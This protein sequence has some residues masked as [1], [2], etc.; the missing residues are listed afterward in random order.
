MSGSG[1]GGGYEYQA[2]ATAYVAA[3]ILAEESLRWIEDN[4]PDV[5]ISVAS[6][7][8]GAGD[9][10]CITLR[11][12]IKIE[13]QAKHGLQKDKLWEPL[14]KLGKGLKAD[15]ELY[16]V[17][18]TDSTASKTIRED[19]RH[20]FKRLGQGRND[21]L[22]TITKEV[23]S[24]FLEANLPESDLEFF[25][26]MVII[27]RDL[28][29]GLQDGNKVQYLLSQLLHDRNQSASVWKILCAEGLQLITI[30][31]CRNLQHWKRL[32]SSDGIQL[33]SDYVKLNID[34]LCKE[35]S[36]RSYKYL[37]TNENPLM[38]E[39]GLT[40]DQSNVVSLE[41]VERKQISKKRDDILSSEQGS[42][43]YQPTENEEGERFPTTDKFLDEIIRDRKTK[44]SQGLRIA[45][46]G[47]AGAGKTTLLQRIGIYLESL[48]KDL[49]P[50]WISLKQVTQ[51]I[52][53]YLEDEYLKEV[54]RKSSSLKIAD[55]YLQ[56]LNDLLNSGRVVL[57]LDGADESNEQNILGN[58]REQLKKTLFD[59]VQVILTC[60]INTWDTQWQGAFDVYRIIPFTYPD[61]VEDFIDRFSWG[62]GENLAGS[63][64]EVLR[65]ESKSRLRDM[66]A[67]P[68]RL[69]LLCY[70][71]K[72]G[73]ENLPD[74]RAELY[75]LMLKAFYKQKGI[76]SS[77][78]LE[79]ALGKL[80]VFAL[81]S[82]DYR[83]LLP[84]DEI[85][86]ILGDLEDENSLFWQATKKFGLL[87][88]VGK[89]SKNLNK[90]TYAFWH[91]TFQEYFAAL[92]ISD[93]D[94]FLPKNH[95]DRPI[96]D[97]KYRAFSLSWEEVI[98]IWL[99]RNEINIKSDFIKSLLHFYDGCMNLYN[100]YAYCLAAKITSEFYDHEFT[101]TIIDQII[102]WSFNSDNILEVNIRIAREIL[103]KLDP[104]RI[105]YKLNQL[106][107]F[108]ENKLVHDNAIAWKCFHICE[109]LFKVSPHDLKTKEIYNNI[110]NS[111]I[112]EIIRI[113]II[114]SITSREI[115]NI[116]AIVGL[117][118]ILENTKNENIFLIA[119]QLLKELY[120]IEEDNLCLIT[121]NNN[122]IKTH[123]YVIDYY[124]PHPQNPAKTLHKSLEIPYT[125]QPLLEII[126][127]IDVDIERSVYKILLAISECQEKSDFQILDL[128]LRWLG[129]FDQR[130][131]AHL[132]RVLDNA[133]D[134]NT[135]LYMAA[136]ILDVD[137]TNY[138]STKILI[139]L[140]I[141]SLDNKVHEQCHQYLERIT[142]NELLVQLV[143][144]LRNCIKNT[145]KKENFSSYKN[146]YL[147]LWHCSQNM[148][149]SDFYFAWH[150]PQNNSSSKSNLGCLNCT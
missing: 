29:E 2:R 49:V 57:L 25:R 80:A 54:T 71:W 97:E 83:Y 37:T 120:P 82:E 72:N 79:N 21:D 135:K 12:G 93:W 85:S 69:A 32:L 28:D 17:I 86:K 132:M 63:L 81:D 68:L 146:S 4:D 35:A 136:T 149:Y 137:Q 134:D 126:D 109:Y 108:H 118:S 129:I 19:L 58:L 128:V 75:R 116:D 143:S 41:I 84:E 60:R 103:G 119:Q 140:L 59:N 43:F 139:S 9:D 122:Y 39:I 145:V 16:G 113:A 91:T 131:I 30:R 88:Q 105:K 45:I 3:H 24:K 104:I 38:A 127:L 90:N 50:I 14:I 6:E 150:S 62:D 92:S 48:N 10:L 27:V 78:Q 73:E 98:L 40:A 114:V 77:K 76:Q 94:F 11:S 130:V 107:N 138:Y 99:G 121:K 34:E 141:N 124:L 20:D 42:S 66:V 112:D 96:Q 142:N 5:P 26:R 67:N 33:A 47:E 89:Y 51:N 144:R 102:E 133:E 53:A 13:L 117:F 31:G 100:Y 147:V 64:K 23:Q 36:K 1:G 22:K 52:E 7:T 18:L 70:L 101:N 115:D 123:S 148:T 61:Q 125:P 46:T 87:N 65:D 74:T 56:S 55:Q 15:P 8:G 95:L 111:D 106:L 110:L 44:N